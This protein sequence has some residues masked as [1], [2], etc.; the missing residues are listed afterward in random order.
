VV[1]AIPAVNG[2]LIGIFWFL[3]KVSFLIYLMIWFRG[4]FPRYRYDQL[5]N[6]GWKV[7]IPVGMAS[8]MVNALLGMI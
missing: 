4:T 6:I 7:A 3:F 8:V 2:A 1:F 5:M